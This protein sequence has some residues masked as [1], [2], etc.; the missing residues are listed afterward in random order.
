M[1]STGGNEFNSSSISAMSMSH[2]LISLL[3]FLT[4][5][6]FKSLCFLFRYISRAVIFRLRPQCVAVIRQGTFDVRTSTGAI[7]SS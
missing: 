3:T 7:S 1:N 6:I 2:K 4:Y 5:F